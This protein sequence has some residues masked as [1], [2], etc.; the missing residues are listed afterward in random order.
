MTIINLMLGA[1]RGGL[2]Q[3]A[4]DYAEALALAQRAHVS[5]VPPGSWVEPQLQQLGLPV[6]PLTQH[7]GWDVLAAWRLRRTLKRLGASAVI[8]HGNRALS[9]ALRARVAGV[10]VIAVAHN[11]KTRRFARADACFAITEH[12]QAQLAQAMP[13]ARVF[14]LPNMVRLHDAP[15]RH[16]RHTPPVIGSMGRFVA[17]KGFALLIEAFAL[18]KDRNVAFRG[19]I[20]GGGEE[21]AALRAALTRHGLDDCVTVGGWVHDKDAFYRRIDLFAL[22][23]HHEPFGIVLI[24]AM[25]A[26]LPVVAT[27]SEGPREILQHGQTG[28]LSPLGDAAALADAMAAALA[29]APLAAQLAHAGQASVRARYSPQAMADRLSA[30]L[31]CV[32]PTG[33]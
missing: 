8:C 14:H 4:I 31:D 26:G 20:A 11:Y 22:P 7:G 2:E 9:L 6:L 24:E 15:P 3:A 19:I 10:P 12:A 29:D 5:M 27:E 23:S 28:L 18:L 21:E 25:A 13:A 32:V 33:N 1:K 17:K 16:A 30:A